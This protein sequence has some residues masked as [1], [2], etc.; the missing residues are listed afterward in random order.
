MAFFG[1]LLHHSLV[2]V[3]ITDLHFVLKNAVARDRISELHRHAGTGAESDVRLPGATLLHSF[4]RGII[5]VT[6]FDVL[7]LNSRW[8]I[9]F[10]RPSRLREIYLHLTIWRRNCCCFGGLVPRRTP[11]RVRKLSRRFVPTFLESLGRRASPSSCTSSVLP[12][13]TAPLIRRCFLAIY[14]APGIMEERCGIYV[15][16]KLRWYKINNRFFWFY[17]KKRLLNKI[18]FK[19][20]K[21]TNVLQVEY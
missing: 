19:T 8:F 6:H 15:V 14:L 2:S 18:Y 3:R 11:T 4:G 10:G 21:V 9:L 7:Q 16:T 20:Y 17:F 1:Q 5:D 13:S 12:S